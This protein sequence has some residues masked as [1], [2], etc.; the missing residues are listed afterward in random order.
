MPAAFCI[1]GTVFYR[2]NF[3]GQTAMVVHDVAHGLGWSCASNLDVELA[4]GL[5]DEADGG[6]RA[7]VLV[8]VL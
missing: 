5:G 2:N 8:F 1:G 6:R 7:G 3:V 4:R